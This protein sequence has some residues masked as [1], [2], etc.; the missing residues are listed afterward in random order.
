MQIHSIPFFR[1]RGATAPTRSA[2]CESVHNHGAARGFREVG[3]PFPVVIGKTGLGW[4]R[5]I[6]TF[7]ESDD[8]VRREGDV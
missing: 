6:V 1:L 5:G 7:D 3:Q 2:V 8:P 4:G